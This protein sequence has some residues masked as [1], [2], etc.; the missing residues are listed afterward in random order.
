MSNRPWTKADEQYVIAHYVSDGAKACAVVLGRTVHGI[1]QRAHLLN[2]VAKHRWTKAEDDQLRVMWGVHRSNVYEVAKALGR[3][4]HAT[5]Y[6]ARDLKL[7][8]GCPQGFEFL[9]NAAKRTGFHWGHLLKILRWANV[10]IDDAWSC[11]T[12]Q[13]RPIRGRWRIVEPYD[14]D[15]AVRKWLATEP[16]DPAAD[17][18]SISAY[19]LNRILLEAIARGDK[20]VPEKPTDKRAWRVDSTVIDELVAAY[21][22]E[23]ESRKAA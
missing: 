12:G 22:C 23:L 8:L 17:R 19:K 16:V 18:R 15:E 4:P 9:D 13:P 10:Q 20:R 21:R 3:T 14:V 5:H 2:V 6:R 7:G 11:P 1:Q